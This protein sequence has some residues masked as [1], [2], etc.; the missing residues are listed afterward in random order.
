MD[1][2]NLT[3]RFKRYYNSHMGTFLL[4]GV[5]G[6]IVF[7]ILYGIKVLDVTY[8]DW[9]YYPVCQDLSQH[10]FGWEFYRNSQWMFPLGL[11]D[12][13]SYPLSSSVIFTDSIPHWALFFKVLSPILP[14]PFQYFGL[15]GL[16]CMFMQGSVSALLL[17]NLTNN[18]S[19]A[20]IASLFFLFATPLS[21]RLF[22]HTALASQWLILFALYLY[23]CKTEQSFKTRIILWSLLLW[24][25][26]GIHI[27]ILAIC[28]I[29]LGFDALKTLT[30][31]NIVQSIGLISIPLI[32]AVGTIYLYGG[33][34]SE[35]NPVSTTNKNGGL[36]WYGANLNMMFNPIY[37]NNSTFLHQLPISNH[38][39]DDG[40]CYLGLGGIIL[41][42][43]SIMYIFIKQ[44]NI[45]KTTYKKHIIWTIIM[46]IL[47]SIIAI[48]PRVTCG[49]KILFEYHPPKLILWIWEVFR[50]TGRFMWP[51]YYLT[52]F[53]AITAFYNNFTRHKTAVLLLSFLLFIQ[54]MD[55]VPGI[56]QTTSMVVNPQ[57]EHKSLS[58]DWE[59]IA[60]G[61]KMV[62]FC[63][64]GNLMTLD[65]PELLQWSNEHQM[66]LNT[67]HFAHNY[68]DY[69]NRIKRMA[70][71]DALRPNEETLYLFFNQPSS[72]IDSCKNQLFIREVDGFLLGTKQ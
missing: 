50:T 2:Q 8:V 10:Y 60:R 47:F 27:T 72:F 37:D 28:C 17:K 69:H 56:Y 65:Y 13:L 67:F 4:G 45:L 22:L 58:P 63:Y 6:I 48:S 46:I 53:L 39:S 9:I 30:R 42:I 49:S 44:K 62:C 64:S 19:Y 7:V 51:I 55:I 23:L 57:Q 12:S 31:G 14:H 66:K 11:T 35:T 18:T 40:Y 20:L 25:T 16:F 33:L 3:I 43:A 24:Y 26:A 32:I 59:E 15:F 61:R 41:L 36:G 70:H 38:S 1:K 29:I 54:I 71:L 5:L 34:T 52:L 68:E 21:K